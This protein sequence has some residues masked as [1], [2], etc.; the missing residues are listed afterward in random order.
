MTEKANSKQHQLLALTYSREDVRACYLTWMQLPALYLCHSTVALS[1]CGNN[2]AAS[3]PH[4]YILRQ[5]LRLTRCEREYQGMVCVVSHC[6]YHMLVKSKRWGA[7]CLVTADED[8]WSQCLH[9]AQQVC[10]V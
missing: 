7:I 3:R 1:A 6:A 10:A 4:I 2:G 9:C 5:A 8:C